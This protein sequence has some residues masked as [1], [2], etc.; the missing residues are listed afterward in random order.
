[1][2][3]EYAEGYWEWRREAMEPDRLV[4]EYGLC[5]VCGG[6][7]SVLVPGVRRMEPCTVCDGRDRV[8]PML[9]MRAEQ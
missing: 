6:H 7:G 1:M 4:D 3:G 8:T 2:S 9:E 5:T